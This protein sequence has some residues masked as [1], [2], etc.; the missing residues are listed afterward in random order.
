MKQRLQDMV[1]ITLC[2][3]PNHQDDRYLNQ[4]PLIHIRPKPMALLFSPHSFASFPE[5]YYC[6][7]IRII[8]ILALL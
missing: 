8:L 1:W 4:N 7:K 2:D 3:G 5:G 6:I